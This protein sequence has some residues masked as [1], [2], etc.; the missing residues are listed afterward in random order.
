VAN[1]NKPTTESKY[2]SCFADS[3]PDVDITF[4]DVLLKRP[5]DHYLVGVDN[6]SMTSTNVSMIEPTI[7]DYADLIRVV[8]N[9]TPTNY[10]PAAADSDTPDNLDL[11][12]AAANHALTPSE[13]VAG[14]LRN[15]IA[16][17]HLAISSSEVIL[18]IQQLMHRLNVLA[19]DVSRFM[20]SGG[21]TG[22]QNFDGEFGY[23][24][25]VGETTEHLRFDLR[26]DGRLQIRGTRA[27]WGCFSFE[28]PSPQYQFGFFG[29]RMPSDDNDFKLRRFLSVNP[30]SGVPT[31]NKTKVNPVLKPKVYRSEVVEIF[32]G[33]TAGE[34]AQAQAVAAGN[35]NYNL[36]LRAYNG[37]TIAD[38]GA[39]TAKVLQIASPLGGMNPNLF[40]LHAGA[41]SAEIIEF[42]TNAS[43]FST[44]E[45]RVAIELG[46]SLPI[47]NSPMID[48][49]KESPD[50]VLG[51]WIWRSD[52][53]IE[54]NDRG[55]SRR[56]GSVMPACIE[57]QGP[58]D[59]ISY[60]E[61]QAQAKIQTLRLRL[62]ARVRT[63]DQPTETWKM[64]VIVLPTSATD[65]W[66]MRLH[67]V[68]K[69]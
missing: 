62:F 65:W 7:G 33:Q 28:I 20:N 38:A 29:D 54:S 63:F 41:K 16:T 21:A 45:R 25:A 43:I 10:A 6:F 32:A 14:Y 59:R 57:Y 2:V 13:G 39:R 31:F 56:Y 17:Y 9:R 35:A 50:F 18:S 24:P 66:H 49:A 64:R 60:H 8:R 40:N 58:Q 42:V 47:K 52:S 3:R 53:R 1:V 34:L 19:A 27:F 67:F 48:H 12:L 37:R 30:A 15:Q 4:R 22:A 55:G 11:G 51:R 23:V 36:A 61:L 44:L 26:S 5:T 69:D 46:V 68:S